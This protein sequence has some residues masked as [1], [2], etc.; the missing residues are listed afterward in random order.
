M[1]DPR[2]L[3]LV[4]CQVQDNMDLANMLNP[5]YLDLAFSQ[6]QDNVGL[7]N[8]LNPKYLDFAVSQVQDNDHPLL[9]TPKEM[10]NLS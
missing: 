3:N 2:Y 5:S 4:I 7:V 9:D 1:P 6:V 8:M 10:I